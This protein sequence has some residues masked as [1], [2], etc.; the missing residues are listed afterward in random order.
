[1][2][3]R[4]IV[5]LLALACLGLTVVVVT[6]P[7]REAFRG[8]VYPCSAYGQGPLN[9]NYAPGTI[10]PFVGDARH[11]PDGWVICDGRELKV[12]EFPALAEALRRTSLESFRLPDYSGMLAMFLLEHEGPGSMA[13]GM[14]MPPMVPTGP[15]RARPILWLV[16]AR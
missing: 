10:V 11:V 9:N 3:A 4:I 7:G 13:L 14:S 2:R 16:R 6:H 8:L 12:A 5:S 1:M 15:V